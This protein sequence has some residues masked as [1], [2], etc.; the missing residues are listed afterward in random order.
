MR[1]RRDRRLTLRRWVVVL[2]GL[3]VLSAACRG[4]AGV[5]DQR[6]TVVEEPIA[7]VGNVLVTPDPGQSKVFG[8]DDPTLTFTH[9]GGDS[10]AFTG[11]LARDEGEDVG[12]YTI[13]LGDLS[14]GADFALSLTEEVFTIAPRADVGT[15][16][17]PIELERGALPPSWSD[18]VAIRVGAGPGQGIG[19]RPT[20]AP[21]VTFGWEVVDGRAKFGNGIAACFTGFDLERPLEVVIAGPDG[22]ETR[23]TLGASYVAEPPE[24]GEEAS[25]GVRSYQL[26]IAALPGLRPGEY[27]IDAVQGEA[28]ATARFRLLDE[29]ETRMWVVPTVDDDFHLF[30]WPDIRPGDDFEIVFT[31]LPAGF[32]FDLHFFGLPA[33]EAGG[34]ERPSYLGQHAVRVGDDGSASLRVATSE[35]DSGLVLCALPEPDVV[36]EVFGF[37]ADESFLLAIWCRH[38]E[39]SIGEG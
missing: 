17:V 30:V 32:S 11:A 37:D 33:G 25:A 27:R 9:D 13:T 28:T 4:E 5:S 36:R 35:Q 1:W 8:D 31:G 10:V 39:F 38:Y 21:A 7:T 19:C 22:S 20:Q 16:D 2:L 34:N 18:Q 12:V 14:A 26:L 23:R 24:S 15:D 3:V 6:E 29:A